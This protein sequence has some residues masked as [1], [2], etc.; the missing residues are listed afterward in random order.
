MKKITSSLVLLIVLSLVACGGGGSSS[1]S[2]SGGI[3]QTFPITITTDPFLPVT[4]NGQPYSTT[5]AASNGKGAL[6]WS[7]RPIS[8]TTLFVDG[9]TIDSATGVLSGK[10][11]FLGTAGFVATVT[12]A[13]SQTASKNFNLT[14][15]GPLTQPSPLNLNAYQ[16][17]YTYGTIDVQ[18]GVPPLK[19]SVSSGSLPPG[20]SIDS[21]G[22]LRG[23][24]TKS[25]TFSAMITVQDSW[26]TPQ[27]SVQAVNINVSTAT[28]YV[29]SNLDQNLLV[30]RA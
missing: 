18:G 19:Y 2:G 7:I 30:N 25:G 26:T 8:P 28:L 12:D 23:S 27:S 16:Y 5:L 9:L 15:Y 14:A 20:I 21:T 4:L 6:K 29:L 13:N 24:A 1:G 17:S 3:T 11:T 10:T 22:R